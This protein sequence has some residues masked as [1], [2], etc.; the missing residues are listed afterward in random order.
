LKLNSEH[1]RNNTLTSFKNL[2]KFWGDNAND[3]LDDTAVRDRIITTLTNFGQHPKKY[4]YHRDLDNIIGAMVSDVLD[5]ET[6]I[7]K[8]RKKSSKLTLQMWNLTRKRATVKAELVDFERQ[9]RLK[10]ATASFLLGINK[11]YI[12][13]KIQQSQSGF[14]LG[15]ID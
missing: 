3:P 2:K 7:S 9:M 15:D 14:A 13:K 10:L 6:I 1:V 4:G 8:L 5:R 11:N 12:T